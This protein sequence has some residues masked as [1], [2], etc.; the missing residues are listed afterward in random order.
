MCALHV[1]GR[2]RVHEL[3]EEQGA[4]GQDL[5]KARASHHRLGLSARVNDRDGP[6]AQGAYQRRVVGPHPNGTV[7][8]G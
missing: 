6:A 7:V 5:G 8:H 1:D 4:M 2:S 3:N